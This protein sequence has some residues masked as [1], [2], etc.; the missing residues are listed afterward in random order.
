MTVT[1]FY[2][3][4]FAD[5]KGY[6]VTEMV[7]EDVTD[8]EGEPSASSSSSNTANE[9][10]KAGKTPSAG[11]QTA[12]NVKKPAAPSAPSKKTAAPAVGQKSMMS[13]FTKK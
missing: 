10:P 11:V 6:L 7:W 8:D 3:Q 9:V 4:V 2:S 12:G 13:F 5:E 1:I